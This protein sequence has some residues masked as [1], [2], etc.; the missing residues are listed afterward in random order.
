MIKKIVHFKEFIGQKVWSYFWIAVL[1]GFFGFAVESS[2]VFVLQGFLFSVGLINKSQVFIPEW[3]PTSLNWSLTILIAFG[4]GRT[5]TYWMRVHFAG[6]TQLTFNCEQ[7]S[8]LLHFGLNNVADISSKKLMTIFSEI[9]T[10]SGSVIFYATLLINTAVSALLFFLLGLRLA[11]AEMLIGLALLLIFLLPMRSYSKKINHYGKEI[12]SEWEKVNGFLLNGLKNYFFLKVHNQI[13]IEVENGQV[14]LAQYQRHYT[15]Y[16]Y[17]SSSLSAFPL[18]MGVV[19]IS[20]LTYISINYIKT[21]GVKLISFLYLFVRLAQAA[22]EGNST[23]AAIK[24]NL[25]G[26]KALYSWKLRASKYKQIL[27]LPIHA[28]E[29]GEIE[30][31][32]RNVCFGYPERRDLLLDINLKISKGDVLVIKG[33]SGVGKSTLLS[34]ILGINKP[35]QGYVKINGI[36]TTVCNLKLDQIVGYVGPEP[37]LIEASLKDNLLYGIALHLRISDEKIWDVLKKVE[38]DEL[39]KKLPNG[40]NENINDLAQFS[41]GQ[42]QRISFARALLRRPS[43]L[44][45]DEATANLDNDTEKRLI[46][47]LSEEFKNFTTIVVTHKSSFDQIATQNIKLVR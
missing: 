17:L 7:R 23:L 42:K 1:V 19:I 20:L 3:Y 29:A 38:L 10:Q 9:T 12:L 22:S 14:S 16:S 24:L 18:F 41:S 32:L 37:Y 33:E 6:I 44:I 34:L 21:D 25:P 47:N 8:S 30:V 40:I 5:V 31:V 4:L 36:S 2:F 43:L 45:L 15:S 46:N 27:N 35:T 13:D 26:L 11:P 39:V 28:V